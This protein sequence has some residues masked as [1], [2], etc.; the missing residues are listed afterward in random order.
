M[1]ILNED[2]LVTSLR[3]SFT[4]FASKN[5]TNLGGQFEDYLISSLIYILQ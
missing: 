3:D 4:Q 1:N 2:I 5:W